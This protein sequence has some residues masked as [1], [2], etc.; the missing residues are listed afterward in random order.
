VTEG[1]K[2]DTVV[3][4]GSGANPGVVVDLY[5]DFIKPW[6][7]EHGLLNSTTSDEE[8]SFEVWFDVPRAVCGI[9]YL[10]VKDT[11]TGEAAVSPPFTVLPKIKLSPSGGLDG[12]DILIKGFG[13]SSEEDIAMVTFDYSGDFFTQNVTTNPATPVTDGLG[14]WEATFEVPSGYPYGSYEVYA[15]DALGANDTAY[16]DVGPVISLDAESG[17]VGAVVQVWGRGFTPEGTVSQITLD[18]TIECGIVDGPIEIDFTGEFTGFF[19]IPQVTRIDEYVVEVD[20]GVYIAEADFEVT[21][22]AKI[23][24]EP[25]FGA[26]GMTV[27]I[28]GYNF[29]AISGETVELGLWH[30]GS[31]YLDIDTFTTTSEGAF[32]GSFIVP[33]VASDVYDLVATQDYYNINDTIAFEVRLVYV[34]VDPDW[35]PPGT[36][37]DLTGVGFTPD[38][39]WSAWFGEV[40]I[41]E[42]ETVNPDGTFSGTF[43]VPTVDYGEYTITT[44]DHDSEATVE[45]EFSVR[46]ENIEIYTDETF[47]TTGDTMYLGLNVTNLGPQF[48]CCFALWA[49]LPGVGVKLIMHEHAIT[50]PSGFIYS[51]PNFQTY[52]LPSIPANLYFWHAA[53]L[54]PSTHDILVQDTTMWVFN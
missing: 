16:F 4:T 33:A 9:H 26:P 52:V 24:V 45:T 46:D 35:G 38:A 23:F 17:P 29:S 10:W 37:V 11:D 6:D 19:V 50:L 54:D 7:G 34:I 13:F 42:N 28:H 14:S 49:E 25:D 39:E 12:D 36:E 40:P 31:F 44:V 5:W 43:I 51:N 48:P 32:G 30:E 1:D 15:E 3:V 18:W 53:L 20:D 21:G 8:G 2:G 41:F 47:Y 27:N 22:L